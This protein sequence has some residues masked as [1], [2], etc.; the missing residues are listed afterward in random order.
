MFRG[1]LIAAVGNGCSEYFHNHRGSAY[2]YGYPMIQY[3]RIG[4]YAAVVCVGQGTEEIG[5]FFSAGNFVFKIGE[6]REEKFEIDTVKTYR[7][8]VQAWDST[9]RYTLRDWLPFNPENYRR[10][11]ACEGIVERVDL[12][13]RI[14]IGN[15]LSTCKGLGITIE[16]EINCKMVKIE[17][18]RKVYY[19]GVPMMSFSCEL[20]CNISL[21]DFIG[22]GKGTSIGHGTI[23]RQRKVNNEIQ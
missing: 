8:E 20:T 1:A 4:G 23:I 9:F 17:K 21:P 6:L 14:L 18:S 7:T 12:L 15:I 16:R 13:E 19:K 3:K 5:A 10:Y 2:R 11:L 22:L